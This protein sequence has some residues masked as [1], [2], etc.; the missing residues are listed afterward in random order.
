MAGPLEGVR[1]LDMTIFQQG[2]YSTAMLADLGADVIKIEGPDSPDLGRWSAAVVTQKPLNSYFHSLNRSKRA[3]CLDLKNEDGCRVFH[4]LVEEA[5]V[6][7]SNL[8]RPAL[9][10]LQADYETLSKINPSL[11]YG[12]ASGYGPN[13][14]DADLG[15]MDILGQARGGIMSMT[16]EP[17]RGPKPAGVAV[18]DH[19]GA[20]S[21]AFG[22]MV[23]LFHRERT[24]EGQEVDASL[25]GGQ[26][27]IQTFNITDYLWSGKVRGRI[28]RAGLNP[29]WSI[30]KG[31]DGKY[32][33]LGMNR[34]PQW[35]RIAE[36]LGNPEWMLQDKYRTL[37]DRIACR[38]ELWEKFDALFL[39]QPA[40]YWV[41]LFSDADLLA[42]P[43]NDYADVA[44]DAQVLANG[45]IT[46]VATPDGPPVKMVGLPVI[47]GKT[48]GKI[49]G[50]GPEF[51]QHTEEVLLEAG[52]G[53]DDIE[54]LREAGAIGP[55]TNLYPDR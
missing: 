6:F 4:K 45:Y 46:E 48:P 11:V 13:G 27:C 25:L 22:L 44:E 7:V 32:F 35:A 54:K 53:W 2:T 47:F 49:S 37:A 18:G 10:R 39:T 21:M 12:R 19:V 24:G 30:Y 51:G 15:S 31:S 52:Y 42:T 38:D 3:I 17:D 34:E 23:A 28:P 26:M 8:R 55:P 43:V 33:C 29:T 41:K 1:V 40:A 14:P 36:V 50:L 20:M 9:K 5:D 16:G